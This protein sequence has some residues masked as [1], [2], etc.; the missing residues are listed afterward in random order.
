MQVQCI[1]ELKPNTLHDYWSNKMTMAAEKSQ[2]GNGSHWGATSA[3]LAQV[4]RSRMVL[5]LCR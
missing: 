1:V 5:G 3:I 4:V 2:G